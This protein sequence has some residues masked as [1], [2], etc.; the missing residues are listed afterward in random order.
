MAVIRQATF[1]LIL[2]LFMVFAVVIAVIVVS[3]S[4]ANAF[5][6][7]SL[8]RFVFTRRR[9][10]GVNPR[11]MTSWVHCAGDRSAGGRPQDRG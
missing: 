1:N 4:I 9:R 3:L 5:L 10:S 11:H 8:A 2:V 7:D 6:A